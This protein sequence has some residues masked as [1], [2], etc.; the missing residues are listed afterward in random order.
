MDLFET[1]NADFIDAQYERWKADPNAV[2]PDWRFF[3]QGFEL[4]GVQY[5]EAAPVC[6]EEQALRQSSVQAL[7]S[8]Y[9]NIGH[10]LACLDPLTS[11]PTDH[12]LLNLAAFNLTVKDLD[13]LFYTQSV[14]KSNSASLRDIID[15]LK[16]TYSRSIGV[17]F[18]HLQDPDERRWLQDRMEPVRNHPDLSPEDKLRILGKLYESALFEQFLHKT[19]LGQTRFS[20]EG[21]EAIIPMLD[22]LVSLAGRQ[23]CREIILGMAHRGRLNVQTNILNKSYQEIFSEF[24]SCYDPDNI[25]GSGDV[26]YHNGY[27]ADIKTYE[28][29]S[30]RIFLVNNPI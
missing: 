25:F 28:G 12:P 26:K 13:T 6:D 21:A 17:E 14:S 15:I 23:G 11:C 7:I 9:R 16:E 29:H 19:Y 10:L 22:S 5:K 8:R 18:M 30:L 4:A 20:L 27:L 1:F 2:S 24:E 3:F